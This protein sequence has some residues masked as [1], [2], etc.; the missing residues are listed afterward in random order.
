MSDRDHAVYLRHIL[1]AIAFI[2]GFL[3]GVDHDAFFRDRLRQ[4]GVAHQ[5]QIIGEAAAHLSPDLLSRHSE[6]P[7][8]DIIG[9]RHKIV[10]D[11]FDLDL[12]ALW[13]TAKEDLP[14]LK[15]HVRRMLPSQE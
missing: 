12:D 13:T 6:V 10:H 2:D 3:A 11:Y 8:R 1:D 4:S 7:W 9:M 14:E 5:L 15:E